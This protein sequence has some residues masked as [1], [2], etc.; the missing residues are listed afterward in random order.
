MQ[1]PPTILSTPSVKPALRLMHINE[2]SKVITT[3]HL[4]GHKFSTPANSMHKSFFNALFIG[5]SLGATLK[6]MS[7]SMA[8]PDGL[9]PQECEWNAGCSR[10][11][12]PYIPKKNVIQE[13]MDTTANT[14]MLTLPH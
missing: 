3:N 12:I 10:P 14:L 7:H 6:K 11:P 2:G 8:V 5:T 9:K 13:A 1:E 4:L